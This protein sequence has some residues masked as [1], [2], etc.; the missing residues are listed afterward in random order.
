MKRS[1]RK[2]PAG[3]SV[4]YSDGNYSNDLTG[5]DF[6][7]EESEG[8]ICLS[9]D[10]SGNLRVRNKESNCY[11][12][13]CELAEQHSSL[14]SVQIDENQVIDGLTTVYRRS[15]NARR[16]LKLLL[17]EKGAF[18]YSVTPT[19]SDGSIFLNVC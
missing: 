16:E 13:V 19:E 5:T 11:Y 2:T 10:L 7:V 4:S 14:K 15:P 1:L 17:G 6:I 3:V 9:I 18:K 12:D 8:C